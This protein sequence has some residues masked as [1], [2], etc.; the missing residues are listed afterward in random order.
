MDLSPPTILEKPCLILLPRLLAILAIFATVAAPFATAAGALANFEAPPIA[1]EL[2]PTNIPK[3]P[4]PAPPLPP[5]TK[6][7]TIDGNLLHN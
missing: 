4:L 6:L 7:E 2:A 3:P 1:I 5:P